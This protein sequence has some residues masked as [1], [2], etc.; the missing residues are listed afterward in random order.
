MDTVASTPK[1]SPYQK[2]SDQVD[3]YVLDKNSKIFHNKSKWV[4][5]EKVHGA[6]FSVYYNNGKVSFGK[7]NALL[8]EDDWFYSYQL[9]KP[10]LI[11]NITLLS[12]IMNGPNIVVYG[13]LFGGFYPK[14]PSMWTGAEGVRINKKGFSS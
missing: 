3:K 8:E 5:T 1:F 12:N 11:K 10:Q 9:I 4:V 13:E 2:I 14:D 6:N 7:R